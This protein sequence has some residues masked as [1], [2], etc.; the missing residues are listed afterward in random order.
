MYT[1]KHTL[2]ISKTIEAPLRYVYDW[3]T[4]YRE[5]DP[6]IIGSKRRRRILFRAKN[7]VIYVSEYMKNGQ[8]HNA[9]NVVTL[10]P[11]KGWHLDCVGDEDDEVGE[12]HLVRLSPKQTRLDMTF[13]ESYKIRNAPTKAVDTRLTNEIWNKYVATLEKD[14]AKSR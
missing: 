7:R 9:V 5:S 14:Y 1:H 11:N 13:R 8:P 10:Y 2:H 3:C 4:D 12:Y 6:K